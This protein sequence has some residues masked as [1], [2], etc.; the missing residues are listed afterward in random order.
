ML[1][2]T[3]D[4]LAHTR[5]EGYAVGAFNVYNLEGALAVVAAAEAEQSPAMLQILPTAQQ[6]GGAA[7]MALCV[8]AARDATVPMAVQLDHSSS[9]VEIEAALDA[10]FS[11]VMADGSTLPYDENVAFTRKVV[12]L[13]HTQDAAVEG[14]LGRLSGTED[15]LTVPEYEAKLTDPEQAVD[16]VERT[17]VDALAVCIGNVHGTYP[18]EPQFEFE[19]L[20]AIREA[21]PVPLVLHGA[22]GV[23]EAM[24]ERSIELGVCKF[25]VNTALR[26]AYLRTLEKTIDGTGMPIL[27]EL[28][29]DSVAAMQTVIAEKLRL[30]T[31]AEAV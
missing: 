3:T 24:V 19:R 30:F 29:E 18:G 20:A 26:R 25:N 9:I 17:D 13:A 22:S 11:S 12:D 31:A 2:P 15:G 4:L 10:G 8:A 7:L 28:L 14:E 6:Y 27:L 21:V 1:M 23:P 5:A 16:F